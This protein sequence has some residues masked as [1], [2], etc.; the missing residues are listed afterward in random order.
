MIEVVFI[1]YCKGQQVVKVFF[2]PLASPVQWPGY[3]FAHV[4]FHEVAIELDFLVEDVDIDVYDVAVAVELLLAEHAERHLL[5]LFADFVDGLS[6]HL[7]HNG[8]DSFAAGNLVL[9]EVLHL[10]RLVEGRS[11]VGLVHVLEDVG[12][13]HE[14]AEQEG[15]VHVAAPDHLQDLVAL[16]V[17]AVE[18]GAG[19][20]LHLRGHVVVC[21]V[22]GDLHH[23]VDHAH[24]GEV[25]AALFD[26]GVLVHF[27]RAKTLAFV[28][29]VLVAEYQQF[30]H[31]Y[32][33]CFHSRIAA[34]G[35]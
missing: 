20:P 35:F 3:I 7:A 19:E 18:H 12:A 6:E 31:V 4:V 9:D 28:A 17:V 32:Q 33:E 8:F 26:P 14:E 10:F 29:V 34:N 13:V 24:H 1:F 11:V 2:E 22:L 21:V 23:G 16:V 27:D 5:L 30:G 15:P 25:P